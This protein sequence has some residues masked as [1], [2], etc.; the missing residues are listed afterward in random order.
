MRWQSKTDAAEVKEE[1]PRLEF[2]RLG[3]PRNHTRTPSP[4]PSA[5]YSSRNLSNDV[6]EQSEF[7][8]S[9][10]PKS[11]TRTPSPNPASRLFRKNSKINNTKPPDSKV[12]VGKKVKPRSRAITQVTDVS[13]S[14]GKASDR[15]PRIS[16]RKERQEARDNILTQLKDR[17]SRDTSRTRPPLTSKPNPVLSNVANQEYLAQRL[18]S[19]L[20]SQSFA[21]TSPQPINNIVVKNTDE[22]EGPQPIKNIEIKN[23]DESEGNSSNP[24]KGHTKKP[25]SKSM[26]ATTAS[27]KTLRVLNASQNAAE[28]MKKDSL[29][30]KPFDSIDTLPILN[31]IASV[32]SL[33]KLFSRSDIT[34]EEIKTKNSEIK[35]DASQKDVSVDVS[36]GEE[37]IVAREIVYSVNSGWNCFQFGTA[38]PTSEI[39][40]NGEYLINGGNKLEVDLKPETPYLVGKDDI[41]SHAVSISNL[42]KASEVKNMRLNGSLLIQLSET[43]ADDDNGA[44]DPSLLDISSGISS[45]DSKCSGTTG[46]LSGSTDIAVASDEDRNRGTFDEPLSQSSRFLCCG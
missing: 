14:S 26:L 4:C 15:P 8:R 23:T 13:S 29:P 35:I 12:N 6:N 45:I 20:R 39:K 21:S 18:H 43:M 19:S 1:V 25:R 42:D 9:G 3:Y 44:L 41:K 10:Y 2:S 7:S 32:E 22:S 31:S 38:A 33:N 17:G 34:S 16:R 40:S 36:S 28:V 11:H 30:D 27:M 46:I 37:L 5:R 24:S